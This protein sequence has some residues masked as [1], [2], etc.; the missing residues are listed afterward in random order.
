MNGVLR[1]AGEGHH[2]LDPTPEDLP[3][4]PFPQAR[5]QV[6]VDTICPLSDNAKQRFLDCIQLLESDPNPLTDYGVRRFLQ[7]KSFFARTPPVLIV[8]FDSVFFYEK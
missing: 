2:V 6:D 7:A 1:S 8:I 5:Q 3:S 4:G